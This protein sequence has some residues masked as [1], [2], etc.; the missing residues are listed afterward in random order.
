MSVNMGWSYSFLVSVRMVI[1][2]NHIER[3]NGNYCTFNPAKDICQYV[4]VHVF[5]VQDVD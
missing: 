4:V 1:P 3:I 2:L 5:L